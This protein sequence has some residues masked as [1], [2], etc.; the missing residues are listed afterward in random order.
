MLSGLDVEVDHS[1]SRLR[2]FGGDLFRP[3]DAVRQQ[4]RADAAGLDATDYLGYLRMQKRFAAENADEL[5]AALRKNEIK[6]TLN[7]FNW[8]RLANV[9]VVA[10][11]ADAVASPDHVQHCIR[12]TPALPRQSQR[13]H[14]VTSV[15]ACTDSVE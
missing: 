15:Q 9:A 2:E 3:K 1:K 4:D 12:D 7:L 14:S 11:L 10:R 6:V 5:D 13:F 8:L